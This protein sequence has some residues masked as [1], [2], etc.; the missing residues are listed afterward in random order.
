MRSS[1]QNN[2]RNH[3]RQNFILR[4]QIRLRLNSP[5]M[6]FGVNQ[7]FSLSQRTGHNPNHLN[8]I[9]PHRRLRVN[10]HHINP[11]KHWH[12]NITNLQSVRNRV[13]TVDATDLYNDRLGHDVA[14]LCEEFSEGVEFFGGEG[15][16]EVAPVNE[17]ASAFVG[18]LPEL[19]EGALVV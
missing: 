16:T 10:Q 2:L 3:Q 5:K 12:F 8:W 13:L 14:L 19:F 18:D 17:D 15:V 1:L 4:I 7:I 6:L 11:F 9:R